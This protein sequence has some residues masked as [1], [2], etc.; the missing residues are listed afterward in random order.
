MIKHTVIVTDR[1]D[2]HRIVE[3]SQWATFVDAVTK[4]NNLRT[5]YAV[6]LFKG[7]HHAEL[8]INC[9]AIEPAMIPP[10]ARS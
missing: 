4:L 6:G 7:T 10:E 3:H 2:G 8:I 9:D 1:E 5:E